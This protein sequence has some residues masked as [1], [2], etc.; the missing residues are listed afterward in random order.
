[1]VK[2]GIKKNILLLLLFFSVVHAELK[3]TTVS[4]RI[5][6]TNIIRTF[7]FSPTEGSY[8]IYGDGVLLAECDASGI[9]QMGIENDSIHLKTFEGNIGKYAI[10]KFIKNGQNAAFKIKCVFPLSVVRTYDDELSVSLTFDKSQLLLINKVD[11]ESY[12]AGVVQ[13]ESGKTNNVEY[14]KLQAIICRTYLLAHINRHETED[15]EVCDDVHCQVYL[16]RAT[17]KK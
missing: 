8:K 5:F 16:S 1:M 3:A 11:L 6:T 17:E 12:I 4:V 2:L 9:F 14:Y 10:I 13:S 15:F 7:I